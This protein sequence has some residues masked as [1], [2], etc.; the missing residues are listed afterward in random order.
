[1]F[2]WNAGGGVMGFVSDH[3]GLRGDIRYLRGFKDLNTGD[4]VI[5][6][7]GNNLHFWRLSAGIVIR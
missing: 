2:G 7:N 3:V 5:D 1:M 6:L 4:T